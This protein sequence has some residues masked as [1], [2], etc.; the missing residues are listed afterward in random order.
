MLPQGESHSSEDEPCGNV[1]DELQSTVGAASSSSDSSDEVFG[2]LTIC[3]GFD[4]NLP[5]DTC[6]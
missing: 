5:I 3:C 1:I 6:E 4:V 2:T